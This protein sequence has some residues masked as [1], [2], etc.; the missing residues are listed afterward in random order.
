M[1]TIIIDD[2][3]IEE[4]YTKDE[5]KRKFLSFIHNELKE[6]DID[7]YQISIDELSDK[8]KN[9]L[10]NIDKLNFVNY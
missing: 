9:R 1:T 3:I 6:K 5:L 7:L 8:S 2:P 4:K 10:K